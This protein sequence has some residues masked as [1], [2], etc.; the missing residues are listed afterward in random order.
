MARSAALAL[1]LSLPVK[2]GKGAMRLEGA[3]E[4]EAEAAAVGHA[5]GEAL[6]AS[7]GV[8]LVNVVEGDPEGLAAGEMLARAPRSAPRTRWP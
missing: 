4:R 6:V 5:V 3:A 7:E 2:E 1:A 8:L